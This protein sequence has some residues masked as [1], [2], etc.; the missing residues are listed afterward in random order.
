MGY[1][2]AEAAVESGAYVTVSSSKPEK[3]ASAVESLKKSYPPG[4]NGQRP[5]APIGHV[6]DLSQRDQ[7][8]ESLNSLLKAAA[9]DSKINHIVNTAGDMPDSAALSDLTPDKI[10]K[11]N[12]VRLT[13]V[14]ILAKLIPRYV[15]LDPANS[16]T[17]TGGVN[18]KKPMPGWTLMAGIGAALEG[19]VRGLSVDLKPM[20]FNLVAPGAV[21]TPIFDGA[22]KDTRDAILEKFRSETTVGVV[23]RAEDLAEAYIYLMKDRFVTG[24]VIESNGGRL[25]V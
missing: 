21:H 10:D 9:G 20:R 19:I 23:G 24:E 13:A 2:V 12:T 8:E 3:V 5:Y 18:T 25:F 16:L 17:L 1:A 22:P 4:E 6:C 15:D 14:L 7:I 11:L